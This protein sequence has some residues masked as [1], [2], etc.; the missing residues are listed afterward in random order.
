MKKAAIILLAL[1]ALLAAGVAGVQWAVNRKLAHDLPQAARAAGGTAQA[2][3]LKVSLWR[4]A[5]ELREL[6]V[7][8]MA[9]YAEPNLF[10]LASGR[11]GMRYLPLFQGRVRFSEVTAR[12]AVLTVVRN[13]DGRINVRRPRG[14]GGGGPETGPGNGPAEP[15]RTAGKRG[16]SLAPVGIDRLRANGL[17]RFLDYTAGQDAGPR[18]TRLILSVAADNLAAYGEAA[19]ES[20]WGALTAEGGLES[21]DKRAPFRLTGRLAPV[22]DPRRVSFRLN[23]T[24]EDVDPELVNALMGGKGFGIRGEAGRVEL[25]IAC[26]GGQFDPDRSRIR[27]TLK[28]VKSGTRTVANLTV[29]IPVSGTIGKPKLG[30]EQAMIGALAQLLAAPEGEGAEGGPEKKK[31]RKKGA[32]I[33]AIVNGLEALFK[34]K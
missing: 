34:G 28:N 5:A 18:E 21:G 27:V 3:A 17:V 25:A 10:T 14:A 22:T 31:S 20:A 33:G 19:D 7:A 16:D 4:G 23:G 1:A 29:D 2:A 32:N 6:Q 11:V 26:D 30:L 15:D 9:G 8:N 13:A 12:D 24:M